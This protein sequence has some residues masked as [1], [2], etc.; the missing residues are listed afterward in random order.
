MERHLPIS[1]NPLSETPYSVKKKAALAMLRL[2]R[3]APEQLS[4]NDSVPRIIQLLTSPDAVR[5]GKERKSLVRF[6][7]LISRHSLSQGVVTSV[8]SLVISMAGK[9]P[10]LFNAVVAVA[11]NRMHRV[12][13]ASVAIWQKPTHPTQPPPP[14]PLPRSS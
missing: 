13:A 8:A 11:V 4:L 14:P 9:T 12:S 7:F 1:T 6:N 5:E 10:E 2:T 3:E